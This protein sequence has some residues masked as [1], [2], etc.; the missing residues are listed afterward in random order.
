MKAHENILVF[1]RE[2]CT[3]VPQM[4]D[5]EPYSWNSKRKHSDNYGKAVNDTPVENTGTRYPRSVKGFQHVKAGDV[6]H[7][8]QKPVALFE[9]LIRTYTN[10]GEYVLDNTAGSGTTA[11][12]AENTGRR[13][14]CIERDEDYYIKAVA[15][16]L[17]NPGNPT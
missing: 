12:A 3:Y 16:V 7:P 2:Q 6:V 1:Y 8:T 4:E 10:P 14:T 11:I 15:R 17:D 9:Y 5:G 13:W